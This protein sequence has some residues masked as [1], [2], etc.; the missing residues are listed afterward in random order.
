M[1]ILQK[2]YGLPAERR[3]ELAQGDL[4]QEPVDAIVNAANA[5]LAHG[6]GIAAAISRAGGPVIDQESREWIRTHGPVSHAEPAYTKA[7]NLPARFVIHAVGPVWGDGDEDRKLKAAI[8]GSLRQAS[9]L[10]LQTIAFPAISTGIFRFPKDCAARLFFQAIPA[11]FEE[12]P[13]SSLQTIKIVLW[14]QNDVEIFLKAADLA[15][16]S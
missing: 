8:Q 15:F 5:H 13:T 4:T 10:G 1:S 9:A 14:D 3:I 11:Y 7:G 12:A 6:G 16:H 2:T